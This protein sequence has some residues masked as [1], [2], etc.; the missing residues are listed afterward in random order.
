MMVRKRKNNNMKYQWHLMI[1]AVALLVVIL[2]TAW[3][4]KNDRMPQGSPPPPTTLSDR[5]K[6]AIMDE[7]AKK[8]VAGIEGLSASDKAAIVN[9]IKPLTPIPT[10]E[11]KQNIMNQLR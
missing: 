4:K 3:S 5:E 8:T 9:K 10:V 11:E 1:I 6:Q 7:L 2:L